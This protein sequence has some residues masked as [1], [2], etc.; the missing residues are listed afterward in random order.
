ML[1]SPSN[2]RP[3]QPSQ[4]KPGEAPLCEGHRNRSR[5]TPLC[6]SILQSRLRSERGHSIIVGRLALT[7]RSGRSTQQHSAATDIRAR[8]PGGCTQS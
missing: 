7:V 5:P 6:A 8:N 2:R 4:S 1:G 3:L